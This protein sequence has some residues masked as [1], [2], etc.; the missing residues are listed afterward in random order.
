MS[1]ARW[2]AGCLLLVVSTGALAADGGPAAVFGVSKCDEA[3]AIAARSFRTA[4]AGQPGLKV[5]SE[6]ETAKPFG[7]FTERTLPEVSGAI[8][9]ARSDLYGGQTAQARTTLQGALDDVVRLAPSEARWAAERD[10]LTLLAQM[11]QKSDPK[12]AE[13]ALNRVFRV[14]P[15]YR[16][17]TSNYPPS[18]QK[19]VDKVRKA[20]RKRST[21]RLEIGTSPPGKAVYIGGRKLGV[22]PASV[23]VPPGQYRVEADWGHLGAVRTITV[24]SAPVELSAAVDGA[25]YPDGGPCVEASDPAP[26]LAR[27]ARST[28]ASRVYGV[29]PDTSGTDSY[30]VVT[31]T[32]PQG[33]D[34]REARVKVQPG[35][36][37][38]DALTL[39]AGWAVEG[40][41]PIPVEV[42][43]GPG[44]RPLPAAGASAAAG[45]AVGAEG[46]A[47]AS[48]ASAP[49]SAT[50]P[51]PAPRS[52]RDPS[53]P[54]FEAA[55]R[56]GFG[57]PMGSAFNVSA[58]S[59]INTAM[60]DYDSFTIPVMVD[61]GVRLWGSLFLGGYFA[62]GF[63]GSTE[64]NACGAGFSCTPHTLRVG[65]E[66]IWH[67][68]GS[69]ALDPWV[70]VGSGYE[71][72]SIGVSGD[73][74]SGTYEFSGWEYGILQVG[75]DFALS[76][77]FR[78]GPWISF[79]VGQYGTESASGA[80]G[81]GSKPIP[82]T[83]THEWFMGG[84]RLVILP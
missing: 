48:A 41:T 51:A 66:V 49:A 25:V 70:G 7:G 82:Q 46:A 11:L 31:S 40:P 74:G 80:S 72:L 77:L 29:R 27:M 55:L 35:A 2:F 34:V 13:A 56:V 19:W 68:L 63:G 38:G 71:S 47:G 43:K 50:A 12:E 62:Y 53:A 52:E 57:V 15:D 17:D 78:L 6:A 58:T 83:A 39:L 64:A 10:G 67:V 61:V 37:T 32:D 54:H 60:T 76:P 18:F 44:A 14:E 65:G 5:L 3:T 24:P 16:P 79:S 33:V 22:G 20:A 84:V 23:R 42:V 45:A 4:L 26:A 59:L 21:T 1:E 36:P 81:S 9:S 30:M 75:V 69:A 73:A 8:G 28:G